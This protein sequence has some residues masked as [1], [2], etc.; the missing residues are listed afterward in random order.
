MTHTI[1]DLENIGLPEYTFQATYKQGDGKTYSLGSYN[2]LEH[3]LEGITRYGGP[4][5]NSDGDY[6]DDIY[7][8]KEY[9]SPMLPVIKE[10]V[11]KVNWKLEDN[12]NDKWTLVVTLYTQN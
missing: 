1:A 5:L 7:I 6:I 10:P 11:A 3:A 9:S 2:D 8:Y 4:E 12:V